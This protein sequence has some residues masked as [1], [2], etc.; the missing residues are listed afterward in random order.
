MDK[1][2]QHFAERLLASRVKAAEIGRALEINAANVYHWKTGLRPIPADKAAV[3]AELVGTSPELI[4]EDFANIA[5][6]STS[7]TGQRRV[8]IPAYEI[9]AVEDDE[10]F[11]P[12]TE[13]WVDG[14]DVEVSGGNG[15]PIPEYV[16]TKYR[17][18]YTLKWLQKTGAKAKDLMI[19]RVRGES[20]ER[21]VFDGDKVVVDRSNTKI[22]SNHVYVII[23]GGEARVKRLFR[24]ADGRIRIV[25]DNQDKVTYPDEFIDHNSSDF[26]VIGRVIDKSGPGGL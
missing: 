15:H 1:Y 23:S 19:M 21:T 13:V 6:S 7:P 16:P 20:M 9:E 14:F 10:G 18:R 2:A 8:V 25:S 22:V 24:A 11:D 5:A 17:Q 26:L 12:E 4:S 3:V